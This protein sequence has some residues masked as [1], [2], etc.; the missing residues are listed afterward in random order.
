MTRRK[1]VFI[2][3]NDPGVFAGMTRWIGNCFCGLTR[4]TRAFGNYLG[5]F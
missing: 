3:Q 1:I 4:M 2:K 5:S